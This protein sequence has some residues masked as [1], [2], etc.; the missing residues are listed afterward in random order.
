MGVF[1]SLFLTILQLSEIKYFTISLYPF[2]HAKCKGVFP[3]LSTAF[4]YILFS[5]NIFATSKNPRI[6]AICNEFLLNFVYTL[7]SAPCF[8]SSNTIS[9]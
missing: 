9:S 4:I 3:S 1:P 5:H 6:V 8:I 2:W 7:I